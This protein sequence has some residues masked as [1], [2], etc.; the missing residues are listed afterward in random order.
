MERYVETIEDEINKIRYQNHHCRDKISLKV[1]EVCTNL[2]GRIQPE[3]I[4]LSR[5]N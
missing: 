3:T 1:T 2:E 5:P 4:F